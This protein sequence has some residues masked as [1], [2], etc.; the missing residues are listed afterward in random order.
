MPLNILLIF[1]LTPSLA[2]N[3]LD[4]CQSGI[5]DDGSN[6]VH[7]ARKSLSEIPDFSSHRLFN[8]AFDE[9]ILSDNAITHIHANVFHNLRIKRLVMSGN[10]LKS[11]DK[12]AFRELENYLE[13]LTLEFDSTIVDTIPEAIKTNLANIRSLTLTG[14]NLRILPTNTFEYMKKLEILSLKSCN[15]QT[16]E[17]NAFYSIE[18]QLRHLYLDYNQLDNRISMIINRVITLETLSLSHNHINQYELNLVNKNLRYLDLS[19]NGLMKLSLTNMTNLQILNVQ[20]NLLTSEQINGSIPNQL[21]E[22]ILDFNSIRIFNKNLIT[23]KNSLETLSLQSNDFLLNNSNTFR[24]LHKLKRLN[25]ARNNIKTIPK[26]LFK[27]T[28]SLEHLN[29]D[30]NPLFPLSIDTFSGIESSLRNISFQS[31]SLT[32]NSLPAFSRLINLERLKLQSN[33]LT[34]IKP[35]NFFSSMSQLIGIDLQRNQLITIPSEFPSTLRELELGHNRLT[36]LPF[37]NQ[38]F[39]KLSQLITLDLSSNPLQC[40]C[41]IKSLYHWLLTHYQSELVPYVQWICAQPK[42]LSGKQLGSLLE[43]EFQC[44]NISIKTTTT[45]TTITSDYLELTTEYD[46]I[47]SFNAWLKDSETAILEWSYISSPLKLIVYEN[48]YKL[49]ILYLNSSENYFLLEK[50]KSSTNYTLCLQINEQYSCR[51]LVTPNKQEIKFE[52]KVLSLS[53]SSSSSSKS[54][55]KTLLNDIQYLIMGIA[56]GIV[57]VLLILL[58]VVIFII[59]QRHKFFHNSSK[60]IAT[61][62]YYQTTGSDTTQI[63]GSCSI[64]ERSINGSTNHQSTITPMFYYCRSPPITNCCQEQQPYHFYHEIPFTTSSNHLNPPTC[65]CR[66][67]I[68]I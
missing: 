60:T 21:K 18:K 43:H 45:T 63:G 14:L 8:L 44:E 3:L 28:Y 17:H 62:S 26:G 40:D 2:I 39:K 56:C 11:I 7:C 57:F 55:E 53:S 25:L 1:L 16:I 54:N 38:T 13:Q 58:F 33:L 10:R 47:S 34:E 24:H 27:F 66:P 68:I 48:N 61:D 51:N 50:L 65:L 30:R 12:N 35:D 37:N 9:L 5:R 20:N 64:E 4:L 15:L 23:E 42:E 29:M 6:Y 41:H 19:Y 36:I 32:S 49:P 22:L 52:Q 59:K 31:C 67:P 46:K